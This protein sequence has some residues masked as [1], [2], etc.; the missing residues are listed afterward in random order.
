M[1]LKLALFLTILVA[2]SQ[3][4]AAQDRETISSLI[5]LPKIAETQ[6]FFS[7]PA[8]KVQIQVASDA[9]ARNLPMLRRTSRNVSCKRSSA[10]VPEPVIRAAHE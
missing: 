4:A 2:L 6:Q 10:A 7:E 9:S 5:P 8:N 3:G 1:K